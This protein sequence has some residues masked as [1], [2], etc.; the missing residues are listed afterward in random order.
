MDFPE[1]SARLIS[2]LI[3]V[4]ACFRSKRHQRC[5]WS[6]V[7]GCVAIFALFLF[8]G[9]AVSPCLLSTP[10]GWWF[11]KKRLQSQIPYLVEWSQVWICCLQTWLTLLKWNDTQRADTLVPFQIIER[12]DPTY[13]QHRLPNLRWEFI[14]LTLNWWPH[15]TF[16]IHLAD[17]IGD[18]RSTSIGLWGW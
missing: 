12:N 11:Q 9:G 13:F 15:L 1:E 6:V 3:H 18:V 8:N 5:I 4:R 17:S 10:K 16:G 2:P 7:I 14:V